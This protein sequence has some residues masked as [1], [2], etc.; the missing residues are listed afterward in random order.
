[1]KP[2]TEQDYHE[3]ILRALIHIQQHLDDELSLDQLSAEGNFSK[4]HF[5]VSFT[6]WLANRSGSTFDASAWSEPPGS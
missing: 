2:I 4:F 3:R 6:D 1:M 5:T